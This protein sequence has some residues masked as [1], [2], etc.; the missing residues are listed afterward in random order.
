LEHRLFML[1]VALCRLDEIRDQI[2]AAL[3]LVL[4]LRPLR[5]DGLFLAHE[6][7]VRTAGQRKGDER[8]DRRLQHDS[9]H[10]FHTH[11]LPTGAA[12]TAAAAAAAKATE[13]AAE[14][15]AATAEAAAGPPAAAAKRADAA[16]PAAPRSTAPEPPPTPAAAADPA[17][18]QNRHE[19][20]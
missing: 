3:Q 17:D 20:P 10:H 14:S 15:A 7:V 19:A 1:R 13:A 16:R 8:D 2:V 18:D 4:H 11:I 12:A 9:A 6:L 5:L